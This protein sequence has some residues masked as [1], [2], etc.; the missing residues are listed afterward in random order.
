MSDRT[1]N[2]LGL[3][4][5]VVVVIAA[6]EAVD[7][8]Q[9]L[10]PTAAA[11]SQ[12]AES[13]HAAP[14]A[15]PTW[16]RQLNAEEREWRR[17]ARRQARVEQAVPPTYQ[18]VKQP[19]AEPEPPPSPPAPLAQKP[20]GFPLTVAMVKKEFPETTSCERLSPRILECALDLSGQGYKSTF[21]QRVKLPSWGGG[22]QA[23]PGPSYLWTRSDKSDLHRVR[24]AS[25]GYY[26]DSWGG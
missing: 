23:K 10:P 6:R 4:I 25:P 16:E 17:A 12:E 7:P 5:G 3:A 1:Q 18:Q 13:T 20:A 9:A 2:L 19:Q 14:P 26:N 15:D 8:G 11:V 21:F 22:M 24:D